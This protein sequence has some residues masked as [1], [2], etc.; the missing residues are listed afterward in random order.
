MNKNSYLHGAEYSYCRRKI[1]NNKIV[2]ED[3]AIKILFKRK[4]ILF[5]CEYFKA[6]KDADYNYCICIDCFITLNTKDSTKR[7]RGSNTIKSTR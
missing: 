7:I 2:D 5:S 4:N 1:V 3:K 6:S